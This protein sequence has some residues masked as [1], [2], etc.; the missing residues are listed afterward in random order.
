MG[1]AGQC[2][3]A[4]CRFFYYVR[5]QTFVHFDKFLL[6]QDSNDSDTTDDPGSDEEDSEGPSP[7]P[8]TKERKKKQRPRGTNE[9]EQFTDQTTQTDPPCALIFLPFLCVDSECGWF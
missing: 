7:P 1:G 9:M 2:I 5:D 6:Q 8:P 3:G 4:L